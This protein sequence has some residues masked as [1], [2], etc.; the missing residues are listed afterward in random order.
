MTPTVILALAPEE[1]KAKMTCHNCLIDCSKA[2]KRRDGF[3]RYRCGK[4]GKTYSD[5]KEFNNLFGHKQ[6]VM[7][8]QALLAFNCWLRATVSAVLSAS[9]DCTATRS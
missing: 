2:G 6:A 8:S 9:P 5:H 1:S 7:D 3:Q 4:C